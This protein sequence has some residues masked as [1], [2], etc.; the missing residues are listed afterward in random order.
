MSLDE[1]Y[2]LSLPILQDADA[3]DEQK[4]DKL[5]DFLREKFSLSGASLEKTALDILWRHRSSTTSDSAPPPLRHT[6]IRRSSPAPWQIPR[7]STPLSPQSITGTSPAAGSGFPVPRGGFPR[8]PRSVTASPFTS[9]RPS[10]RLALAQPIPHSPNLNAY[11]FSEHVGIP[12]VYGDFGKDN[13]DWIV[14]DD[15]RG[16]SSP[17]A[18]EWAAPPD[19]SPYDILRSVLGDHK[20]NEEIEGALE[21]NGYDFNATIAALT[22]QSVAESTSNATNDGTILVGKS[23]SMD[24][25]RPATPSA[26]SRNPVICKYWLSTGQCFRADCH[27]SHDLHSHICK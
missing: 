21:A 10:P 11:E 7:S 16:T 13:V 2:E 3:D 20:S 15:A 4:A 14:S 25:A 27:F 24:N 8:A 23:T 26:T 17:T 5:E 12:E 6:I 22:Q 19:M 9:P 1:I 18:P